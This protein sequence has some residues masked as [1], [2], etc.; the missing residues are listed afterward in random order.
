MTQEHIAGRR[1]ERLADAAKQPI[2][3]D[4][5]AHVVQLAGWGHF[6]LAADHLLFPEITGALPAV[7]GAV[8]RQFGIRVAPAPLRA[9]A[10]TGEEAMADAVRARHA[11]YETLLEMALNFSGLESR[12]LDAAER[13][14]AVRHPEAPSPSGRLR[15]PPRARPL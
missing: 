4:H 7:V 11:A 5:A 13:H 3:H 14:Q 6:T 9:G 2:P 10:G 1:P 8:I 12:W 15:R